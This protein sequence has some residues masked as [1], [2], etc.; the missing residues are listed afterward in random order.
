MP[1]DGPRVTKGNRGV[2]TQAGRTS[3]K[4]HIAP[5]DS[6]VRRSQLRY[7]APLLADTRWEYWSAAVQGSATV[8]AR[9]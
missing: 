7:S 4:T 3:Y 2:S 8:A 9:L 5:L 6:A 1:H